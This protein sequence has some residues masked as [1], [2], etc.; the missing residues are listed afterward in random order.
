MPPSGFLIS[1]AR[2]RTSSRFASEVLHAAP[3][4]RPAAAGRP[5][6]TPSAAACRA[7]L[8][9]DRQAAPATAR[10][11]A[12][13]APSAAGLLPNSLLQA[14]AS[15]CGSAAIG[16]TAPR[17]AARQ[18]A[19]ATRSNSSSAAWLTEPM[20]P[21]A[22]S[23]TT[24]LPQQ[25]QA[26]QARS[27]MSRRRS[28]A[29]PSRCTRDRVRPS[30]FCAS[31]FA[32]QRDDVGL[33]ASDVVPQALHPVQV[34]LVVALVAEALRLAVVVLLAESYQPRLLRGSVRPRGSAGGRNHG[35]AARRV[36]AREMPGGTVARSSCCGAALRRGG[37]APTGP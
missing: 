24:A 28:C 6:E 11:R 31:Q 29:S 20:L 21:S 5:R 18:I 37:R 30:L 35:C 25:V 13:S 14:C 17:T 33:R 7:A 36:D 15:C 8:E 9:R 23:K 3:R 10:G 34:L 4:G 12:A 26:R 19:C 22:S 27:G 32:P 16:G 2:L 1:C